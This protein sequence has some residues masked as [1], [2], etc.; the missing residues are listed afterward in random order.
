M[1][2][3]PKSESLEA[4]E[5]QLDPTEP[6]AVLPENDEPVAEPPQPSRAAKMGRQVGKQ[7]ESGARTAA[8]VTGRLIT[9]RH[10]YPLTLPLVW[11]LRLLGLIAVVLSPIWPLLTTT[12]TGVAGWLVEFALN[13]GLG[14]ALFGAGEVVQ[15]IDR[16]E[17]KLDAQKPNAGATHE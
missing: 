10:E 12:V 3:A 13:A 7:L 2:D 16:I 8:A 1:A 11:T 6:V 4:Q 9:G 14:L 5:P 17:Q 15:R